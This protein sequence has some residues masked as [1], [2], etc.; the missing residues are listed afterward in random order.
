MGRGYRIP[1]SSG[2]SLSEAIGR[3]MKDPSNKNG[4]YHVDSVSWPNNEGC[5]ELRNNL[6]YEDV[7]ETFEL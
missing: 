2:V 7:G 6:K 3:F 1:S 4:N 5:S